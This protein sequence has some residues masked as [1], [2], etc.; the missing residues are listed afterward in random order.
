MGNRVYKMACL[1]FVAVLAGQVACGD[2]DTGAANT[3]AASSDGGAAAGTGGAGGDG[4]GG[5]C[6]WD[7]LGMDAACHTC[8]AM[9]C[10]AEATSCCPDSGCHSIADC[11]MDN[12]CIGVECHVA[13]KCGP[14]IDGFGGIMG[15]SMTLAT[16]LVTCVAVNCPAC[17]G[18]GGGAGGS[19]GAGGAGG[20]GTAG[21][22]GN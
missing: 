5:T 22:A 3:A 11:S 10:G 4:D 8:A 17:A 2:D 1:S 14:D 7:G 16:A 18:S 20:A 9:Q 19:G 21:G 12:D 6:A 13:D 15:R